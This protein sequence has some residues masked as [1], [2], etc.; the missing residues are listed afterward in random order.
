M[1]ALQTLLPTPAR[2]VAGTAVIV[3]LSLVAAYA[4]MHWTRDIALPVLLLAGLW[5]GLLRPAGPFRGGERVAVK[6]WV[7]LVGFFLIGPLIVPVFRLAL[8]GLLL[9]VAFRPGDTP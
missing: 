1:N 6:A 7:I 5:Y 2:Y 4:V 8:L 9:L 3:P